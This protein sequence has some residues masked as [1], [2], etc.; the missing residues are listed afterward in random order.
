MTLEA[1]AEYKRKK[2]ERKAKVAKA[3]NAAMDELYEKL[4]GSQGEKHVFRLAKARHKASLDLSEVRAMKDEDGKVLRDPVAVKQ[5]WR[6]YFS[7][8]LNEEFPRKERVSTPPTAGPI[9]P[10][11]IEEVRKV[12]KKMKVGKAAGPDGVPAEVWKSLG[13]LGLQWLTTFFNNITWSARIPQAWR[14][15]VI[16]PIFER[17]G[18]VMD[19]ANYRGIKLIAH[20]MKIHERLVDM[21]LRGVVEIAS[22]QFGF[23]PER[24]AIDAIFIA[25]QVMEKYREKNKPCHI[26][27]LDLE[28]A[29]DRL[30]RSILWEVMR[31]RGILEYMVNIVRDMYDGSNGEDSRAELQLKIRKWQLAL[32]DA[33]LKLNTKK[34]EV[35]S[36]TEEDYQ[37]F[38]VSGTAFPQA[39]EFQYLGS[40]LSADGTVD[41]A[42]RGRIKCAWL[43][44]R[45]ST[46]ILCDRTC[47]RAL[48]GKIYR[49]VVRPTLMHGS[50]CWPLSKTHERMLN[51]VE[52]RMLRWTCG[53]SRCDRVPNEDIRTIMQTAPIQPK[54]RAQRLRWY[55]HVVRRPL[56]HPS[57]QA[58][59]MNVTGKRSRGAPKKRWRDAVKKDTKEVGVT[60]EDTQDRD[61]WRRRTNTAEPANNRRQQNPYVFPAVAQYPHVV[62]FPAEA[63]LGNT[64]PDD[65]PPYSAIVRNVGDTEETAKEETL[66][67]RYSDLE[68]NSTSNVAQLLNTSR[69]AGQNTLNRTIVIEGR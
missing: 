15:N 66:P 17:K 14:D 54:L 6:T 32:A 37:V 22:D 63:E 48:K 7:H 58:M 8:L 9:Q 25:R 19:C 60:K 10:W 52:M 65:P 29:Y 43:K 50:E 2:K 30:P 49:R 42:V 59:E 47:S 33:G 18:G 3:K 46:G 40:Y 23:I 1:L 64:N 16:V 45:E 21:R 12:V 44:W 4:D 61:L 39:K 13:E 31:E 27:F 34:T 38:D 26:A 68:L 28:K 69:L 5:R 55:G 24:S 20:T 41:A 53:L 11:T 62:I 51:T 56:P 57:R 67:P 36:S 35:M